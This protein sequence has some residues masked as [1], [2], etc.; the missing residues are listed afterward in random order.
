[1]EADLEPFLRS[2]DHACPE[3]KV[4]LIAYKRDIL[5]CG[6][7]RRKYPFIEP[8][9]VHQKFNRGGKV[10]RW[11]ARHFIDEDYSICSWFWRNLGR[12]S[13]HIMLERFFLALEIVQVHRKS[14]TNVL[15]TD[16]RDVVFQRN[17]FARIG[18]GLIS[19]LE[20][21][22]IG[23]CP[24]NSDWIT[25]IYGANVHANLCDRRVV[26]AGVTLGPVNEVEKYLVAMCREIWKCLQKVASLEG[27][28]QGIHNYV[29]YGGEI[30]V[31][32]T[33]NQAGMIATL[34]YEN[35]D[36]ILIDAAAGVVTVQGQPPAIIHQYDRHHSLLSFAR[37]VERKTR[38]DTLD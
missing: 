7:L 16:S 29:I 6:K 31:E 4:F 26:C 33:E 1:M 14:F 10:Y 17:P 28:D 18:C 5:Q 8:V 23:D 9:Y 27:Y 20:E 24:I 36:N 38:R 2:I 22:T 35:P 11:V 25:S 19:G 15:L 37:E 21:K 34:Q 3:A 12:Y 32:L 30:S 13:L